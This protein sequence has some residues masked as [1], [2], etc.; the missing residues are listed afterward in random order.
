MSL[1]NYAPGC[2]AYDFEAYDT[3]ETEPAPRCE[4]GDTK[5]LDQPYCDLCILGF[6]DYTKGGSK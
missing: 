1:Y 5:P 4:C 3:I 6:F 2:S